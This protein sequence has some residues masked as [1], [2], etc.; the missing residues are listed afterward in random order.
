MDEISARNYHKT[1]FQK[2]GFILFYV[3]C[4]E[5]SVM[6]LNQILRENIEKFGTYP[7]LIYED[8]EYTNTYIDEASS[9]LAHALMELGVKKG[10]RVLISMPNSPEVVIGF[11]GILKCGA[12]IVPVMPLL[13]AK[14]VNYIVNDCQPKIILTTELLLQKM[15]QAIEGIEQPPTVYTLDKRDSS[16]TILDKMEN[17]SKT[18]PQIEID[19]DDVAALLYTSGTTGNPKGVVLTHKNLY[20]NA[21]A[22][23]DTASILKL[24]QGRVALGVL[25]FSHAFGFTMMNVTLILGDK[26]VLLPQFEPKKVLEAIEKYKVTHTAMVPAMFHALLHHPDADKYDTSSFFAATSGSAPLSEKLARDFQRKFSCIILEGYGLSEAAPIVTATDP[27]KKIKPGSVGTPLPGI[28]IAVVDEDGNRLPPNEVGELIVRGP[29]VLK[30]YYNKPNETKNVLKDGWLYTGDMARIDEDG[31]LFI[32]DR[33]KDLIIRGGFNIYPRDLE[34]L[35]M[36]HPD[37]IEAGVVGIP[38]P[39]MGEEV[40]AYVVKRK[41]SNVT[42]EELIEYCQEN[43]AKY[44][45]PRYIKIVGF[46]PKNLI[47]KIDKKKL[48]EQAKKDFGELVENV[49]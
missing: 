44:K 12:V 33:K 19:A 22:A 40:V 41:D 30:E 49:Q 14:E 29:N 27:T 15:L 6:N 34:E 42:E 18:P 31:Y 3:K 32:V 38:S 43:L 7:V 35:L 8:N 23:A 10:D 39:K 20:T 11:H 2:S 45:T 48:R 17:A 37:V 21:K 25:P 13:Q 26:N 47:G 46:L 36:S 24:K 1:Y 9:Q 28:E 4:W 16:H 5:R